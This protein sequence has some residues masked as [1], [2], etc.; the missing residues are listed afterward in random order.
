MYSPLYQMVAESYYVPHAHILRLS[1][2]VGPSRPQTPKLRQQKMG[3]K[4]VD[5]NGYKCRNVR[6]W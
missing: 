5:R 4:R 1:F 6:K 3:G 2:S